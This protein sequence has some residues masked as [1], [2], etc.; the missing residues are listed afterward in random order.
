MKVLGV[1]AVAVVIFSGVAS[2]EPDARLHFAGTGFS[3]APLES[4]VGDEPHSPLI[5]TLPAQ[6]GFAPNVNIEIQA[7]DGTMEGYADISRGQFRNAGF[8]ILSEKIVDGQLT[9]EFKGKVEGKPLHW[10]AKAMKRKNRFF[11]V[12]AT[13]AETQWN[14]VSAKLKACVDSFALDGVG[15]S[16]AAQR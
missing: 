15:Q 5:M 6:D 9:F 12:T 14:G 13:A 16:A 3:I 7:Y 1:L 8:E 4:D 11:L 10:Y 2:A